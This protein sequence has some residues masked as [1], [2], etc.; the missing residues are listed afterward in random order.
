MKKSLLTALFT[1]AVMLVCSIIPD[2][3]SQISAQPTS[4]WRGDALPAQKVPSGVTLPD[5]DKPTDY[6]DVRRFTAKLDA[7]TY[8]N[9]TQSTAFNAL[10][11]A[12]KTELDSNFV[13]SVWHLDT[14]ANL[15]LTY[16]YRNVWR[17][18]QTFQFND[19]A[20]LYKVNEDFFYVSGVV[21]IKD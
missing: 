15:E 13:D 14:G 16:D 5:V 3:G 9:A 1:L 6:D 11:A 18:G 19:A 20:N 10:M 17:D 7:T 12:I 2:T 4:V 21:Y 8:D